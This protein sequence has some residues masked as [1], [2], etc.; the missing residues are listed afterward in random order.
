MHEKLEY[1]DYIK[2]STSFPVISIG[3]NEVEGRLVEA[4]I[5]DTLVYSNG[6]VLDKRVFQY[7]FNEM[8]DGYSEAISFDTLL[9]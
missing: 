5:G 8:K 9:Y 2:Y 6:E 1:R 4:R 7:I 3:V